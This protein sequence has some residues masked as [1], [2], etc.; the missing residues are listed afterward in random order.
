MRWKSDRYS[1]WGRALVAEGDLAR[2]ERISSL[3]DL[4]PTPAI[5]ARRSYGDACLNSDGRAIDMTRLDR[6]ISFDPETGR[7]EVEAGMPI[8][9]LARLFAPRGW[10]PAVMP[11]T[12]F[13]TVGGCIAMD[14]HG[15]N[16]H[17]AGS[18]GAHVTAIRMI[19]AGKAKTVTPKN[20]PGLFRATLGGLGQ[21]GLILSATLQLA[22]CP[23]LSMKVRESR[24][25]DL[26]E[27]L[28]LLEASQAPYTV[29][30]LDATARGAT[31][32]RGI[33][34]EADHSLDPAP[35]EGR[36]KS[37]PVD[38]PRF[39]LSKPVVKAFNARYF[40]RI[41]ESGRTRVRSIADFFFPLDRVQ[42]WNKLYGK[43]GFHQFQCVL[44][45]SETA[46]LR[47]MVQTIA[48][49]GLASPLAVLKRLGPERAGLMSFPMEGVT[50]AVDFPNRDKATALIRDLGQR[51]AAAGGRVYLAKDSLADGDM[52]R[53]MYPD[54]AKW[55]E[56]ARKADPDRQLETDLVRRLNL[57]S[58]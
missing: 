23:G 56:T 7:A 25:G 37:V 1:G 13:A 4:P 40:A 6:I 36:S 51:T 9:E 53:A 19:H 38:A 14:V 34:E 52:I 29:G 18:F 39:T 48:E 24:A 28:A 11:G 30:W 22:P 26:D 12:G 47:G 41:P 2:P 10:I 54:H 27:H 57:R 20:N 8:G 50:L 32:G 49:S 42:D 33:V 21:T 16:H 31:L 44:P 15:K 46:T 58:A 43:R 55:V 3:K 17:N 35:K 45:H 5:G